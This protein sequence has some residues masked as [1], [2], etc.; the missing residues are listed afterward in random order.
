MPRAW[1][2]W[3]AGERSP[4]VSL[5][6]GVPLALADPAGK[7]AHPLPRHA[8]LCPGWTPSMAPPALP[9]KGHMNVTEFCFLDS[10]T[11]TDL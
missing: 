9:R 3:G 6:T 8:S 4:Q 11:K 10:K 1:L 5:T 2:S 7:D